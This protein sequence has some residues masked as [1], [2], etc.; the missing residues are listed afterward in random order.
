[1]STQGTDPDGA[2]YCQTSDTVS[3]LTQA[4]IAPCQCPPAECN[5]IASQQCPSEA[6]FD[7]KRDPGGQ[8]GGPPPQTG[9][10]TGERVDHAA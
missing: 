9:H 6:W 7:K 4:S 10:Q 1:M 3:T 5:A 2:A 8:E